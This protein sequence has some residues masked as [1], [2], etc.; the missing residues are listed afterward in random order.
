MIKNDSI[1]EYYKKNA[2]SLN[3]NMDDFLQQVGKTYLGKTISNDVFEKI[4]KSIKLS[5]KLD[6]TEQVIDL[7]C[8]N[9]LVTSEISKHVNNVIGYDL[10][11]DLIKIANKYNKNSN[12]LYFTQDIL[13]IKFKKHNIKKIYMYEVLQHF[14]YKSLRELLIKL[15]SELGDFTFFIGSVPDQER[16]INFYNTNERKRFLFKD[17]LENKKNHLGNWWYKEHIL[18]LSE[19][20]ELKASIIEQDDKLHTA[21]YR[22]DVLIEKV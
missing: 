15:K 7:G 6:S 3:N 4:I 22:F 19:E 1:K 18:L 11:D 12:V 5:L 9:G 8:A 14:E 21:H 17:I 13:N 20:L 2:V 16:I 10:S